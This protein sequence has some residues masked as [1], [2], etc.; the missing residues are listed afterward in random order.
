MGMLVI[1][2]TIAFCFPRE[3]TGPAIWELLRPALNNE[4]EGLAATEL[5][6]LSDLSLKGNEP[7]DVPERLEHLGLTD[8][9]GLTTI[10]HD[11]L[12]SGVGLKQLLDID[13]QGATAH[14]P[15]KFSR[16]TTGTASTR[17]VT[18]P[19][20]TNERVYR[21]QAGDTLSGIAHKFLGSSA[22]YRDLYEANRDRLSSPDDLRQGQ[23]LRIPGSAL[24]KPANHSSESLPA[25]AGNTV[26][27]PLP[28]QRDSS[29]PIMKIEVPANDSPQTE[30]T[31]TD[32]NES[33][34]EE[35]TEQVANAE[36]ETEGD[37]AQQAAVEKRFASGR[38]APFLSNRVVELPLQQIS[39]PAS[40]THTVQP[41]ETLERIAI[42]YFGGPQGVS[43]LQERN[44]ELAEN[45]NR[46][47]V[48]Q[49]LHL[50]PQ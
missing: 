19:G 14:T 44:P 40:G 32:N 4:R 33:T 39:A 11:L 8:D 12:T 43:L 50:V 37:A 1:G 6:R 29:Q 22:R 25:T 9:A 3:G 45:P 30:L 27:P 5:V 23:E 18:T 34:L 47:Q 48:G 31:S 26:A 15:A 10:P 36:T 42:R 41:G 38:G 35:A 2:F 16:S 49:I 24:V 17:Q 46:L 28:V 20:G 13:A 7:R 21:V